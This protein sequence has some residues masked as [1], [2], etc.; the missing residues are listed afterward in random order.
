MRADIDSMIASVY[1]VYPDNVPTMRLEQFTLDPRMSQQMMVLL[2][3]MDVRTLITKVFLSRYRPDGELAYTDTS[4]LYRGPKDLREDIE[5]V[6]RGELVATGELVYRYRNF[7]AHASRVDA[8]WRLCTCHDWETPDTL[9]YAL[10]RWEH[11]HM[12]HPD[13]L[14]ELEL[15]TDPS[16]IFKA[17]V[18]D[19]T[20]IIVNIDGKLCN[21]KIHMYDDAFF[22]HD[23]DVSVTRFCSMAVFTCEDSEVE[24]RIHRLTTLEIH[25]RKLQRSWRRFLTK[26]AAAARIWAIWSR[27]RCNPHTYIGRK[28]FEQDMGSIIDSVL[29]CK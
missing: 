18:V 10:D 17:R 19:D 24:F 12:L 14:L 1:G 15:F 13:R 16:K 28:L 9:M 4:Y 7:I 22:T 8:E 3:A 5:C 25:V 6:R 20:H 27:I 29:A 23:D 11:Q 2:L 26:R 21:L